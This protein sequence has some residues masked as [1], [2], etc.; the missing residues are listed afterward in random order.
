MNQ[1][2]TRKAPGLDRIPVELLQTGG[3]NILHAVYD[4]IF[5]SWSDIYQYHKT[6]SIV[7]LSHCTRA[8]E[9]N[10]SVI[11]V[12]ESPSLNLPEKC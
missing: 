2:I 11:T 12:V 1:I 4:F 9:K 6:G 7:F 3:K 10:P 8:R 5:I